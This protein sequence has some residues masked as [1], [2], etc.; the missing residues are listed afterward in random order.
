LVAQAM[1][2]LVVLMIF[3]AFVNTWI[4]KKKYNLADSITRQV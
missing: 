3:E 1:P 2:V 4:R